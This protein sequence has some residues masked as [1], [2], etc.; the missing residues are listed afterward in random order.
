MT[1]TTIWK[2]QRLDEFGFVGRGKSRHRPRN[3]ARLYGGPYPF[4]QTADIMATDAYITSYSQT[5]SEFGIQQSKIWSPD[6]LCMTIAGANTAKTA[7]L[8]IEAC[9]PDSIVGFIPDKSKSDL[10]FVK[11]SLDLMRNKF[12]SVS[13]GA[14]QDNLSLDKL[15]SFPILAPDVIE[16]RRIG[17]IL[18]AYDELIENTQRRIKILEEMSLSLYR[19]WFVHFRYPGHETV[20][21]VDSLLGPIPQGWK[22]GRLGNFVEFKSGFAF[23]SVGFSQDGE[24]RLVTIRNVQDGSFKPECDS[25]MSDL[26][27]KLPAHCILSDCDILLSLTGN[28]GRVCLVYGGKFY[29]NQRVS[30]LIP[31]DSIDWAMTYCMFRDP[32]MRTKL[33]QLSNGVAQQNLSPILASS[34]E[35]VLPPKIVRENFARIAEPMIKRIVQ[36]YSASQNLRLTRDLLLPRLLS[37]QISLPE[38]DGATI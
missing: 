26:P 7:I 24:H 25:L 17:A 11:Y 38:T 33:E 23:K 2:P 34:M 4:I 3:D 19:E 8:K 18:S 22:V 21:L 32:E 10:H 16:Q 14:T 29:L 30:R 35:S 9:F 15:L 27:T 5:Y 1:V 6:T 20:P 37:G 12:L 36:L 31:L 13:R 28:V